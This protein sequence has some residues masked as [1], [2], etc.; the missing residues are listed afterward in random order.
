ME[1]MVSGCG[2]ACTLCS[3]YKNGICSGC[4]L[5]E[6]LAQECSIIKCLKKQRLTTCLACEGRYSGGVI[7]TTY[8]DALKKC[9]L[10][11][12]VFGKIGWKLPEL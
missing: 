2:F 7:C 4:T 5:E 6:K 3:L 11:K 12:Y 10:R 9:I 8:S 1:E